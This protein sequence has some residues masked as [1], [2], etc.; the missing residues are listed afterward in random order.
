MNK[1]RRMLLATVAGIALCATTAAA[2]AEGGAAPSQQDIERQLKTRGLPQLGTAPAPQGPNP[3]VAPAS[4]AP[5][6]TMPTAAPRVGPPPA[7]TTPATPPEPRE[8]YVQP[9]PRHAAPPRQPMP[10]ATHPAPS[11]AAPGQVAL[12]TI[13]FQFG[14]AELRPESIETLRNLGNALNQGLKDVRLF[15]IE[16][17][18][19]KSGSAAL[20]EELSKRRAEAVKNYLV[21]QMGVA[22][23]RLQAVGKGSTEPV[24]ARNPYGAENRR[25][26]VI[27]AGES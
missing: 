4:T 27:N 1:R 16:G 19:D 7:A 25:V 23:E 18:T 5:P 10:A 24:N 3:G 26:I 15:V 22:A 12:N 8:T 14:S 9:G 13:T 2:A 11:A 6:S 20:N 17:H 21:T